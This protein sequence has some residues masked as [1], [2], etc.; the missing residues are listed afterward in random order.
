MSL[1][2]LIA[3]LLAAVAVLGYINHRV[4]GW[5]D[6]IGIAA[7]GLLVSG[8]LAL[9]APLVPGAA[10]WARGVA[11]R[12]D[13]PQL[14]LHG[15]LSVMLFA[16]SLH[17]NL[18]DLARQ[19]IPVIVLATIGVVLSTVLVGFGAWW[20]LG[21]MGVDIDLEYCLLF[22]ALISP[23]DPI[24]VLALLRTAD[25]PQALETEIA[26]ESLFNDGTG[27]VAFLVMLGIATGGGTPQ[28]PDI[29]VMLLELLVGGLTLGV[30]LGYAAFAL[31]KGVD[32]YP[33][34]IILTLALATGGYALAERIE[35]SAPL[36]VVAAGL[37]IGN[38]GAKSAMSERT[39]A[40]LFSF[41]ELLDEVLN[42]LLFGLIGLKLMGLGGTAAL[43][44]AA[45][46]LVPVVLAARFL[47][48]GIPALL[49]R[50]WLRHTTPHAVKVLTWGGV[51][52]GISIAL[53]LSLPEF[54]G[55]D[56][57]V[58][59]TYAVVF[60]SLLVQAPTLPWLLRRLKLAK[61]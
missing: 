8:V 41:W 36:T 3:V 5:P 12:F 54:P 26:G 56:T 24:A 7:T 9:A 53:A 10:N 60:F 48:T 4:I 44:P 45:C 18:S 61:R 46:M 6:A 33:V 17:I 55:R 11:A 58:V 35:V 59:G 30:V 32:S 16:A 15:F 42:L 50:P 2:E 27:V 31:L 13:L 25:V 19:K 29:A 40:N 20:L 43:W 14:L 47:S 34:E 38:H 57:L 23:T 22:G 52:G 49:V 21:A 39:R 37:V 51:R 28:A 1:L